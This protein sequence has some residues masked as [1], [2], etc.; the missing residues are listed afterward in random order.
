MSLAYV[1]VCLVPREGR[2][3]Y[4]LE[5]ETEVV[6]TMWGLELHLGPLHWQELLTAAPTVPAFYTRSLITEPEAL[7]VANLV[8]SEPAGSTHPLMPMHAV[9]M[10]HMGSRVECTQYPPLE[11]VLGYFRLVFVLVSGDSLTL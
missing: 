10:A 3:L 1:Y 9:H 5:L 7:H 2:T 11:M 4:P 8:A 6:V